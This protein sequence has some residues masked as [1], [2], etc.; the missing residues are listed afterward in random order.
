MSRK[1]MFSVALAGVALMG[2]ASSANALQES[3]PK[4]VGCGRGGMTFFET[5]NCLGGGGGAG[6]GGAAGGYTKTPSG[7]IIF[8]GDTIKGT[9]ANPCARC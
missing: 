5:A 2:L 3:N 6:S 8:K 4:K 9:R 1:I 7:T